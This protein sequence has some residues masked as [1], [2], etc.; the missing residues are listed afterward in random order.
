MK[1]IMVLA[2]SAFGYLSLQAQE[3]QEWLFM[4]QNQ[5]S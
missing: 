1:K 5:H 2:F 3:F 4:S